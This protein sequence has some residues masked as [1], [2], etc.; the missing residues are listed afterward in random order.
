LKPAVSIRGKQVSLIHLTAASGLV[1]PQATSVKIFEPAPPEPEVS[2]S[3]R[4]VKKLRYTLSSLPFPRGAAGTSYTRDW[5]K[6]FKSTLIHW[7]A[8][9]EDPFGTNAIMEDVV[10]EIWKQVFPSIANE[11]DGDSRDAI[12]HVVRPY[13]FTHPLFTLIFEF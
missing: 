13:S 1:L 4:R 11:V 8:T 12:I 6:T 10:V 2:S 7:A 3:R 9:L 5:R